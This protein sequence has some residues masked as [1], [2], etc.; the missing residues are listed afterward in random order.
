M[1]LSIIVVYNEKINKTLLCA[2]SL[3][4]NENIETIGK[5]FEHL[6]DNYQF[7]PKLFTIDLGKVCYRAITNIFPNCRIFPFYFH[8][9]RRIFRI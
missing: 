6:K 2:F 4:Y 9:L 7:I 8:L 3:I 5:I 1:K